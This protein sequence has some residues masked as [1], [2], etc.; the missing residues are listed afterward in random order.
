MASSSDRPEN[1]LTHDPDRNRIVLNVHLQP[2]AKSN[3]IAGERGDALKIRIAA[4]AVDNKA[5]AALV[6]FVSLWLGVP[7]SSISILSGLRSRRKRIAIVGAAD[8]V[9]ARLRS[10]I[11]E[12]SD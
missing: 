2:G 11:R 4:P 10:A 12:V 9:M 5:N 3:S 7:A 1:F 8:G 6:A